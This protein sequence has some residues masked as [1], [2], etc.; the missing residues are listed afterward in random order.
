MRPLRAPLP[1]VRPPLPA[2]VSDPVR[3]DEVLGTWQD[4]PGGWGPFTLL[5]RE[6]TG[7]FR[8]GREKPIGTPVHECDGP[9][10]HATSVGY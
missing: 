7:F 5:R 9:H 4:E 6:D 3:A 8:S 1:C 2:Q 10:L